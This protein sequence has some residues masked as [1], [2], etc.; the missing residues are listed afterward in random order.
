MAFCIKDKQ[1]VDTGYTVVENAFFVNYMPA[2]PDK[3][4]AVYLLGLA[5][6]DSGGDN[7]SCQTLANKLEL[8]PEEVLDAFRYWEEM[9]LVKIDLLPSPTVT[10]LPINEGTGTLKKIKAHKYD[11]F[12][13]AIQS[14]ITGRMINTYEFQVY[15][16]FLEET[17]FQ[18]EALVYVAK[19]CA[20]LKGN[21]IGYP[22]I[23]A[24]ARNQIVRGATTLAAVS[25]NLDN[26]QK[27]DDDLKIVL[28]ALRTN[29]SIDYNDR[30]LYEKWVK[31]Y[32]FTQDAITAIAK[33]CRVGGM[34]KLDAKLSEYYRKGVFDIK[35]IDSYEEQKTKLY[36]LAR[37]ITKSIGVYY[38]NLDA[39]V[40]EYVAT[41]LRRGYDDETL[42]AVAKY[43]FKSGIR[44]LAGVSSIIDKLYK[45]G[46]VNLDSLNAYLAAIANVDEIIQ[47]VLNKCGLD[48]RV[49]ANDRALFRIWTE[50]WG[51]PVDLIEYVAELSA[52]TSS[53]MAYANR[54]LSEFK[55]KGITTV[56]QAKERDNSRGVAATVATVGGVEIERRSY[57]DEEISALFTVLD[58]TED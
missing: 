33:T 57:T 43:C 58:E 32:G 46:V 53:P 13:D 26:Q 8:T 36:D 25:E 1:L 4:T 44:T 35:E 16:A 45:N 9:G 19:Y 21:N 12:S 48:R 14:V 11:K 5:L 42:L 37:A 23:L 52:G 3:R 7:N 40:E 39:V 56:Q 24:V 54:I 28:K 17:T 2:A 30:V 41:W 15:Y 29:R 18:P 20:E 34:G 51:L 22:Y 49:T 50:N 10:Y 55:R 31:D 47:N 38:Q 27:Y 6:S